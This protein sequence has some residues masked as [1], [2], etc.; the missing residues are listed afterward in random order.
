MISDWI[1]SVDGWIVYL[2]IALVVFIQVTIVP[3]PLWVVINAAVV[4]PSINLNLT[5]FSGWLFVLIVTFSSLIGVIISYIIGRKFGVSAIKWCAGDISTFEKWCEILNKKGKIW[6]ALT[7]LL[8]FFP[9]DIL[10]FAAG[11]LKLNFA[12]FVVVN[13]VCRLIGLVCMILTLGLFQKT[14]QSGFP[15]TLLVWGLLLIIC[16]VWYIIL[17]FKRKRTD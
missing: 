5:S 11:S 2:V 17:K 3:L 7:V 13:F 9:D 15:V 12:Y 10:C 1:A 6:Y 8:P 16:V 14:N 4:I